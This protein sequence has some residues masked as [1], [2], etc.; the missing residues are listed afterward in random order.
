MLSHLLT[1][2]KQLFLHVISLLFISYTKSIV[3]IKWFTPLS[4]I[5]LFVNFFRCKPKIVSFSWIFCVFCIIQRLFRIFKCQH[6][7]SALPPFLPV[8]PGSALFFLV[9][10]RSKIVNLSIFLPFFLTFIKAN[11][12]NIVR[13]CLCIRENFSSAGYK[14]VCSTGTFLGQ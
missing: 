11:F 8:S 13:H 2:L 4:C 12:Q 1:S 3:W 5:W 6:N 9:I 14:A 7:F 10:L